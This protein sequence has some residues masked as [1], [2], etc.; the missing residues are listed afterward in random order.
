MPKSVEKILVW[1]LPLRLF[2]WLLVIAILAAW[3]TSKQE[4][5]MVEQ[6][7][8]IGYF[9]LSLVIFRLLWGVFGTKHA[10]F[11][12][13]IPTPKKLT[14][15]IKQTESTST[16]KYAGHNPLGSLMVIAMIVLLLL[17]A[18]SGLFIN[19]DIFS[20]G[21]YHSSVSSDVAKFMKFI[22][23]NAFDLIL[24]LT[25]FHLIAI[26]FYW[27]K[28][29]NNLVIPMITGKKPADQVSY[30]DQIPHSQIIRALIIAIA[31]GVFIYWLVV[32]NVPV[33]EEYYY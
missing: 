16:N 22:H 29:K 32:L 3:F 17:Q 26:G 4:G 12:H 9:I 21:P 27:L 24:A 1:D 2:H 11:K 8:L 23:H 10:R 7:M 19:D 28:K 13:F 15:Y 30:S 31:V 14:G 25:I 33:V 6:H 18:S 20:S 5:E